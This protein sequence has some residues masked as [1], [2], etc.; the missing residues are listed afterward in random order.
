MIIKIIA[1][2]HICFLEIKEILEIY[3]IAL[4]NNFYFKV[5]LEQNETKGSMDS[6]QIGVW[7]IPF[8]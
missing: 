3:V 2:F 7:A 4:V 6:L 5:G 1:W 8:Y